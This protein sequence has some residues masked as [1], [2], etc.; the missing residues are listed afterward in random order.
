[1]TKWN[2]GLISIPYMPKRREIEA[3]RPDRNQVNPEIPYLFLHEQ[4]PDRSGEVQEVNTLFLTSKECA[5][6]CLMCDLWKNTLTG[7]LKPGAILHQM[8]YALTR[9]PEASVIKLYNSGNFFDTKAIPV[10]DYPGIISRVQSYARIIVENHPKLCTQ[11]C[12]EFSRQLNGTLE[13]A[14]GLESIHPAVLPRLN[15]QLTREDFESAASFLRKNNIE[16]RAF[17]LLNPPY[18]TDEKENIEWTLKTVEFA[19]D[20]GVGCCSIIPTRTGNGIMEILHKQGAYVPP[21]LDSLEEAFERSLALNRGRVFVD[22]W[23]IGFLSRCPNCFQQR[24]QRLEQMNLTQKIQEKISCVCPSF[25]EAK[26]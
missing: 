22:T 18:L 9:L 15:K 26:K 24:K 23:D 25:H 19:F 1:M 4:E 8:D 5:F 2:T 17:V 3:L 7:P 16:L 12:V 6:A 13:I 11:N 14:L 21:S 10:E 20:C